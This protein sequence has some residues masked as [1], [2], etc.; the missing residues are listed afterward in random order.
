MEEPGIAIANDILRNCVHCGFCTATCPTYV[1]TGNE[2]DSPRGRIYLFRNMLG[3]DRPPSESTVRHTDRCLS[4]LSCMTTCPASVDYMH[5]VD[6][7]RNRIEKTYTRSFSDRLL[8]KLLTRVLP[9]P[10]IFRFALFFARLGKPLADLMPER[11][12]ALL[13]LAPTKIKAASNTGL[14]Q[15]FRP[16]G[17]LKM[18]VAL[19]TGCAQQVLRPSINEASIRLLTRHGCEVVI[20]NGAGC[21]GAL[22]H[23]M[24]YE[25]DATISAQANITAWDNSREVDG[26]LDA[27]VINTSGCGTMVKDYSFMFRNDPKWAE[28]ADWVSQ[29]AKDI[30]EVLMLLEL[31]AKKTEQNTTIAY[32]SAC[33]MQHGQN[34]NEEPKTLLEK[35]GFKVSVP[36]EAHLC[37]GSAGTYNITQPKFASQLRSRKIRNLRA[38]GAEVIAVGNIGC[39][40]QLSGVD[41]N[42]SGLVVVHTVELLDWATGGPKPED[43]A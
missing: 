5:L 26:E 24:G 33:S 2:L 9:N 1:L 39:L 10:R 4:C 35:A 38:T 30:T 40:Q 18:R 27:I 11:I 22:A 19:M 41:A 7:A 20:A 3:S 13:H 8:R 17:K 32:H 36:A 34:I 42:T 29:K 6:E 21:C 12:R 15:I 28:R 37:C 16:E 25:N 43:V 31:K 14:P 23:H